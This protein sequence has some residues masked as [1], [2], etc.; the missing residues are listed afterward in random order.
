VFTHDFDGEIAGVFNQT[1]GD[2]FLH[3]KKLLKI[4]FK[5]GHKDTLQ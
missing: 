5:W 4:R 2:G 1:V 3:R